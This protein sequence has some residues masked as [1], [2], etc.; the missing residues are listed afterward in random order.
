MLIIFLNYT[1]KLKIINKRPSGHH[2]EGNIITQV[3]PEL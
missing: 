3:L 1:Y 2:N